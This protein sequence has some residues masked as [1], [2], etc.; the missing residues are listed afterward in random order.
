MNRTTAP[1]L[2]LPRMD[3]SP[4]R[5]E[6]AASRGARGVA[7]HCVTGLFGHRPN[8]KKIDKIATREL[9][10]R[11]WRRQPHS[12][13]WPGGDRAVQRTTRL[14]VWRTATRQRRICSRHPHGEVGGTPIMAE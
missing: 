3:T 7:W 14:S 8:D 12:G 6:V 10:A 13:A 9:G 4:L 11:P 5:C 2:Q 1:R